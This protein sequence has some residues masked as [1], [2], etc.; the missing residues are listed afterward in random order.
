MSASWNLSGGSLTASYLYQ[1]IYGTGSV[2]VSGGSLVAT[3]LSVGYN[4]GTGNFS[5]TSGN[6][7]AATLYVGLIQGAGNL[8]ISG[9]TFSSSSLLIGNTGSIGSVGLSGG[10]LSVGGAI[11]LSGVGGI[12]TFVSQGGSLTA[13]ALQVNGLGMLTL[14]DAASPA[15]LEFSSITLGS[16]GVLL[17]IP[18]HGDSY[19]TEAV[20][21]S[22]NPA[23]NN[24]LIAA[25]AFIQT[26]VNGPADFL[27]AVPDAGMFRLASATSAGSYNDL[28]FSNPSPT[29]IE[30][31]TSPGFLQSNTSVYALNAGSNTITIGSN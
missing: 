27:H 3:N 10:S 9:G 24:G 23:A 31:V 29:S 18:Y 30:L 20:L 21:S 12:G 2:T 11:T 6:V 15:S 19:T 8:Q 14:N 7:S 17:V 4:N 16:A 28:N 25:T 13:G 5:L 22:A 1:G 26:S